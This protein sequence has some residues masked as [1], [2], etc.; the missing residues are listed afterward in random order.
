MVGVWYSTVLEDQVGGAPGRRC[1][2]HCVT[3]E[4]ST[5]SYMSSVAVETFPIRHSYHLS[6]TAPPM[7]VTPITTM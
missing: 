4:T 6:E 2:R 7:Y 5:N 1:L 3:I